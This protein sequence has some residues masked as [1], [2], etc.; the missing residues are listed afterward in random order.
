MAKIWHAFWPVALCLL[1]AAAM[2][3]SIY[4]LLVRVLGLTL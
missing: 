1:G 4:L 2:S 3:L